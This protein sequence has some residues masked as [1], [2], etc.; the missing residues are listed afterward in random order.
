MIDTCPGALAQIV[1]NLL[2]NAIAHAYGE[3]EVGTLSLR[4]EEPGHDTVRI[5]FADD[6][7]GIA[8]EHIDKVFEPF[9]T[10][11]RGRGGTGLGLHIVHDLVTNRLRGRIALDSRLG[12]GTRF[13]IDLPKS[14]A[15]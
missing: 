7:R 2:M 14:L 6:G 3:G 11:G 9:F 10:T 4:V 5:T 8:P 13:T 15:D 12:G 1:T